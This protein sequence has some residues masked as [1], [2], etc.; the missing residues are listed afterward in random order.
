METP[1]SEYLG[2]ELIFKKKHFLKRLYELKFDDVIL[3]QM[4]II[5]PFTM[6]AIVK[7]FTKDDV[8]FY[9][10]SLWSREINIKYSNNM[11]PFASYKGQLFNLWGTIFLPGG[12][13][14]F[15]K[16]DLFGLK[17]ELKDN[18]NETLILLK[19]DLFFPSAK[20]QILKKSPVV[21]KY[22]WLIAL[23][24]YI[25]LKRRSR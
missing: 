12:E 24:F 19:S 13:Q 20:I 16:Y 18:F 22:P 11:L 10:T 4:E 21:D 25:I 6:R 17:Y 23:L 1:I 3:C 2:K 15:I 9:K 8:E 5:N 14:L 7:G